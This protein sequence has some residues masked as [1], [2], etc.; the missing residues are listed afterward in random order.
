MR[1]WFSAFILAILTVPASADELPTIHLKVVGGLGQTV[2]YRNF[3]EPFWTRQLAERSG[4][5]VTAEVIP[6]DRAGVKGGE[7][8]GFIRLGAIPIGTVSLS[9]IAS[10]DPEAAAVDL[11]GLNP[12]VAALRSSIAAYLPALRELYQTRYGIEILAVW[13]YPAQVVFCNRSISGLADLKGVKVRVASAM[14]GDF[15]TGL[16]GIPITIPYDGLMEALRKHVADCAITAAMS[17]YRLG[18]QNVTTHLVPVTVSWGPYVLFANH[19][20]WQRHDPALRNFLA[21]QLDELSGRLW[22]ATAQETDEGVACL[23]GTG[24]CPKGE[25]GHMVVVPVTA[26]DRK[27]VRESLRSTVLPRWAER[28]GPDCVT[29]WNR[30]IGRLF[31]MSVAA[32]R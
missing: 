29:E 13:S 15:V 6:W 24:P 26:E 8:L 22:T 7:L 1:G 30:T 2:Q 19:A 28:C 31:D 20:S 17:G 3:E 21:S 14:H 9:Q 27:L 32:N 10:E 25:P 23:T 5:K 11:A 4:G 18:L 16:G 12:D